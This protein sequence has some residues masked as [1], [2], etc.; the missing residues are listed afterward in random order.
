MFGLLD[1]GRYLV[2][3]FA[4]D[5]RGELLGCIVE[6]VWLHQYVAHVDV[7]EEGLLYVFEYEDATHAFHLNC[8]QFFATCLEDGCDYE[9]R[10]FEFR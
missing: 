5:D 2:L 1:G 3:L 6:V 4:T 7:I 10:C 8:G 9:V